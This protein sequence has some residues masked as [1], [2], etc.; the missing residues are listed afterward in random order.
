MEVYVHNVNVLYIE[1]A[2]S[3]INMPNDAI[4]WFAKIRQ[5][6]CLSQSSVLNAASS[7]WLVSSANET[8][9]GQQADKSVQ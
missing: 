7:C 6:L 1:C 9:D 3:S 8:K 4:K 2:D 5:T